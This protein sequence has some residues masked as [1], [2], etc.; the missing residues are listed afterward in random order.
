[1]IL[2]QF[3]YGWDPQPAVDRTR[4]ITRVYLAR[5]F[6]AAFIKVATT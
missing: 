1:M 5:H 6:L 2:R 4:R 3:Q